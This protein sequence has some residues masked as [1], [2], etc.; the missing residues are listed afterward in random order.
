MENTTNDHAETDGII[1]PA[2]EISTKYV[3]SQFDLVIEE[4]L[5]EHNMSNLDRAV[6]KVFFID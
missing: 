4:I 1:T 6:E 2:G 3:R 5:Q